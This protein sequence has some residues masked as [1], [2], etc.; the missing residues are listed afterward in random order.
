MGSGV[1]DRPL[2]EGWVAE[3]APAPDT[4]E[5]TLDEIEDLLDGVSGGGP[6]EFWPGT[7]GDPLVAVVGRGPFGAIAMCSTSPP[8]DDGDWLNGPDDYGR[9]NAIFIAASRTIIPQLLDRARAQE[10]TIMDLRRQLAAAHGEESPGGT[11]G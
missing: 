3:M 2:T 4:T 8:G 10:Q 7:H 5:R 6:W 9:A 11:D 1:D